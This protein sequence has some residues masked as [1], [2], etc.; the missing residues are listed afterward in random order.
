MI[1]SIA[2][3]KALSRSKVNIISRLKSQPRKGINSKKKIKVKTSFQNQL[4]TSGWKPLHMQKRMG[5]RQE[6]HVEHA[7][8]RPKD[9]LRRGTSFLRELLKFKVILY[10]GKKN[11]TRTTI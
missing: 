9:A 10:K 11:N 1:Q 5:T 6:F 8:H 7:V 4:L 2:I 3:V